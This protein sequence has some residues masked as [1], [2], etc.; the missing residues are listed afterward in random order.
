MELKQYFS[1]AWKWWWLIV[2][3][4]AVASA[5]S[6][7][8]SIQTAPIYQTT[9]TLLVGQTI[10]NPNPDASEL[11]TSQQLAPTYVQI[12]K[13]Q[14]ILQA[15]VDTLGL[16]FS[17][18]QLAT[19]VNVSVIAGTQLM[20]VKVIDTN[21]QRAKAMADEIARQ[22]IA[23]SPT[24]SEKQQQ[25]RRQF[26]NSQLKDLEAR[27]D[28]AKRDI[29]ELERS[30]ANEVS[31]RRIADIQNQIAGKQTQL[32][33]WQTNYANLLTFVKGGS[34]YLSVIELASVPRV[35]I[36]PRTDL[37]VL[38]A[39]AIGLILSVGAAF[40]LEYLDD[41][42]K[43]PDDAQRVVNLPTL[44]A[45]A[46]IPSIQNPSDHL[47]TA[48]QPKSPV[49]E[50]YRVLRTNLQ[51]S[52]M[53][54]PAG[55]LLVTSAGPGEGKTTTAANLA[56]IMAQSQKRVIL[57]DS[58]LRRP[59]LHKVFGLSNKAGLTNLI[60]D[61]TL[62]LDEVLQQTDLEGLR[63][64]T[65][66][67]L[68]PNA[69]DVLNS[70]EMARIID[71]LRDHAD[72][73]IFDSPPVL[74]VADSVIL[75]GKLGYTLM[76]VDSGRARSEAIRR[77]V[78]TLNKVGAKV[79]GVVLNK[80]SGKRAAYYYYYY[81]YYY[82]SSTGDRARRHWWQRPKRRRRE[83]SDTTGKAEVN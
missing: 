37:N 61:E 77:G 28:Q 17:W 54:N 60:L 26:V 31:A 5:F 75:A 64:L 47:V 23:Q 52:G 11:F 16:P 78:D 43:T 29:D 69:A 32:N 39:A 82:Y 15:V 4:V 3:A 53:K 6:Y 14:P 50:A 36:A 34:N 9:A 48:R 67:P 27:I 24:P 58:D 12:A 66:G 10:Q 20:E 7:A 74:V 25:E 46:R 79:L 33:I 19:Q 81:Y 21:P 1:V 45:I 38:L 22:L 41:T 42:V 62:P 72:L 57:V 80:M 44:G 56:V 65:S 73:V 71:R 13:R 51:F 30:I 63:V 55:S 70:A 76:V 49:S 35:P 40:L 8:A 18:D 68:P 2:L 59:G 83:A